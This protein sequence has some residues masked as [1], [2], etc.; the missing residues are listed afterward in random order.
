MRLILLTY[1]YPPSPEV[2]GLRA[3]KVASFFRRRG[4]EVH[5]VT[6]PFEG[7]PDPVGRDDGVIEHHVAPGMDLRSLYGRLRNR[8][9]RPLSRVESHSESGG[10]AWTPPERTSM[11]KRH[12]SAA[13]WLPDDRQGWIRPAARYATNLVKSPDDVVYTTAPPFSPHIA[14]LLVKRRTGARWVLEFRDPWTDNPWKPSFVRTRWS[15]W[16]ER[17]L[18]RMC[19]RRADEIIAVTDASAETFRN[20]LPDERH[21]HVHV[22]RNGID[23]LEP[24]SAPVHT[25]VCRALYVGSLYQQRDP[26]P[27]LDAIGRLRDEGVLPLGFQVDFVGQCR[28]FHG[29]S[30]ERYVEGLGLGDTVRFTD[31]IPHEECLAMIRE[32]DLLLLFAQD[33][34]LQVPNKLYEYLGARKRILAFADREGETAGMLRRLGGHFVVDRADTGTIDRTVRDAVLRSF[35]PADTAAET[36]L[37]EWTTSRQFERLHEIIGTDAK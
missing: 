10:S 28:W 34:P 7:A 13:M 11:L 1:F 15:D 20:R 12:V 5:V 9:R 31:P 2:G 26:R 19:L 27:F 36:M 23:R 3:A 35:E 8:N 4:A 33:Q 21:D 6:A 14:G 16:I 37:Q 29:E 18:E 17:R 32:A 24:V 22:V 30:I 25:N